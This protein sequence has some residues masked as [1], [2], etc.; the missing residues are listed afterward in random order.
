MLLVGS[1]G[2]GKGTFVDIF[3]ET[4]KLEYLKI[5]GSKENNIETLRGKIES[6]ATSFG[7]GDLKILYIN[8]ADNLTLAAQLA[9]RQLIEDV[10]DITRFI[11]TVNYKN[12]LIPEIQSRCQEVEFNKPPP[13]AI[14]EHCM[15]ILDKENVKEVNKT[16]LLNLIKKYYPDIRKIINTLQ[17][18]VKNGK[19]ISLDFVEDIYDNVI[20]MIFKKDLEGIR[21]TLRSNPIDYSLLYEQVFER[22]GEFKS[23][24]DA[25]LEIAE[26]TYRDT[27]GAIKEITFIAMIVKLIQKGAI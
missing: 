22:V 12:R 14:F 23:P 24:G 27:V 3:L 1:H 13:K 19:L 17:L 15:K 9:L 18:N 8:E 7:G 20:N 11:F 16:L 2:V 4:T 6:F 21:K 10:N 5:N 26:A 25:I